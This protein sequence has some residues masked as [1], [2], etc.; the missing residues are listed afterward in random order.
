MGESREEPGEQEV[1][2][3]E[4]VLELMAVPVEHEL[5]TQMELEAEAAHH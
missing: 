5:A 4:P 1:G 2:E 3:G